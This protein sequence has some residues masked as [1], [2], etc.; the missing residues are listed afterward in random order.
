MTALMLLTRFALDH[1]SV[2]MAPRHVY[3]C[4]YANHQTIPPKRLMQRAMR[5]HY[6]NR[7]RSTHWSI[8]GYFDCQY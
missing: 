6:T 8:W 2:S 5:K 1:P 3:K 4:R 7:Y